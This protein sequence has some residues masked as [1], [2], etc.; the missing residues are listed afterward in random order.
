MMHQNQIFSFMINKKIYNFFLER[1]IIMFST[2]SVNSFTEINSCE[3][4]SSASTS[5]SDS[6]NKDCQKFINYETN[7]VTS[8]CVNITRNIFLCCGKLLLKLQDVYKNYIELYKNFQNALIKMEDLNIKI[9]DIN[10]SS[11]ISNEKL[12][13]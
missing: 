7:N 12:D 6:S 1:I 9:Q 5:V 11:S 10:L 3:E 2:E 13:E 4:K 8:D